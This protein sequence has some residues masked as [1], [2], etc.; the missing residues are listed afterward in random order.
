[1]SSVKS[2]NEVM[3][4]AARREQ[5]ITIAMQ[6]FSRKGYQGTTT[7]EIANTAGVSEA[8]VYR[9]FPSKQDLYVAILAQKAQ[10]S[11]T[12][13]WITELQTYADRG[14]DEGLFRTLATKMLKH[15]YQDRDFI[16]LMLYSALEEHEQAQL[17]KENQTRPLTEF[18]CKYIALRQQQGLFQ[19][20]NTEAAVRGFIGMVSH[21]AIMHNL[22][23]HD[24]LKVS[25]QDA[26]NTFAQLFLSG[27]RG[28]ISST[29]VAPQQNY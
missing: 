9:H 4:G 14:D 5:L 27:L 16:R 19:N 25:D 11:N 13:D 1:M 22:K 6:L 8:L 17:F 23:F 3:D 24:Q 21:H 12:S 2:I 15:C 26:I 29:T 20:C 7:R 10:E 28:Q 18:L